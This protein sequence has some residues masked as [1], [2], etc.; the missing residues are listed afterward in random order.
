M[1]NVIKHAP[2]AVGLLVNTLLLI[3]LSREFYETTIKPRLQARRMKQAE[4]LQ[5]DE[6]DDSQ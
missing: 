6:T 4:K 3:E 5:T 1:K 2:A